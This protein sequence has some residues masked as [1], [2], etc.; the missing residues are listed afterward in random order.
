MVITESGKSIWNSWNATNNALHNR[1]SETMAAHDR[2]QSHLDR[3]NEELYDQ[4]KNIQALNMAIQD[5]E[6]PLKV[7]NILYNIQGFYSTV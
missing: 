3:T 2:L 1:V 6:R 7:Q 4:E 5:K